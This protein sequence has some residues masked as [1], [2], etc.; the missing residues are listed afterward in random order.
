MVRIAVVGGINLDA[1]AL[2]DRQPDD[3]RPALI[4]ALA[5]ATGGKGANQA[6]AAAR[7]GASVCLLG[8]VG[9]DAAGSHVLDDLSAN[10][11]DC[12][13]VRTVPGAP[14]GRVAGFVT[15]SGSKRTAALGGANLLLTLDDVAR[16]A[17]VIA[18]ADAL[19]CQLEPPTE[20]VRAALLVARAAG[21]PALL[22]VAPAQG[23]VR[24]LIPL[25]TW[26]TANHAEA[27]AATGID[28]DDQSTA[29]AAVNALR[30]LG[31]SVAAVSVGAAGQLVAW[32]DG[33]AWTTPRP[34]VEVVDTA[35]AG[36]AFAVVLAVLLA[37]EMAPR[38]VAV[39][40]S[41]ASTLACRRLGAQAALPTRE[42]IEAWV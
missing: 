24:S 11:V 7:I 25:A 40:A 16:F 34:D 14:T 35:G 20:V 29:R 37:E 17:S 41:A 2:V 30:A 33:E 10:G 21:V 28:V 3:D 27:E 5:E 31:P 8:A 26:V 39:R 23:P 42:E 36:D 1:L 12:T 22:D 19:V 4:T 38:D 15:A 6:V 9:D 18:G 13:A 32:A